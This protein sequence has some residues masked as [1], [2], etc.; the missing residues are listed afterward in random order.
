YAVS[1]NGKRIYTTQLFIKGHPQNEGD[2]VFRGIRDEKARETTCVDLKPIA[3]SKIGELAA[4]F[5]IVMGVTPEDPKDAA[6]KGGIGKSE[7]QGGGGRG[8]GGP[9]GGPPRG[10][11]FGGPPGGRRPS[12]DGRGPDGPPPR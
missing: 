8:P 3:E 4:N 6:I 1:Q 7:M 12:P 2:G 10:P 11:G 9:G 5:D